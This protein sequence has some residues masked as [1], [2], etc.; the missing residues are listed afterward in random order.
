VVVVA[1]RSELPVDDSIFEFT[2]E[3]WLYPGEAG[4]HFVT[5]PADVADH[6]DEVGGERAGFGSIPVEATIGSNTWK[7]SLFP[8]KHAASF[9]LPVKKAIRQKER[10]EVGA[11]VLVRLRYETG[12]R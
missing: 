7:T 11:P 1:G 12:R 3:L 5:L 8:D 2:S 6:I 9:L 4:W 10:L